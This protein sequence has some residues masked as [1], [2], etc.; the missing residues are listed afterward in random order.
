MKRIVVINNPA[1]GNQELHRDLDQIAARFKALADE[2][3]V[4][5]TNRPGD[6]ARAI[7]QLAPDADLIVAA[8]GD[9]TVHECV[10]ALCPMEKRP[11]F[12]ILPGGTCNDFSRTLGMSQ[13]HLEAAEQIL[14]MKIR[15]VDVGKHG[16]RYFLNFW[17]VGLITRVS[18]QINSETKKRWGRLAYY[19]SALQKLGLK[20]T[21]RLDVTSEGFR[22]SGD[23][24]M[25]LVGNGTHVGGMNMYFPQSNV[26]DGFLD[27][28]IVRELSFESLWSLLVSR[29]TDQLP[30]SGD[31]LCFRAQEL[32]VYTD[33]IQTVD[34]DGEKNATTPARLSVLPGHLRMVTGDSV[35]SGHFSG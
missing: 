8:G 32:S 4:I 33:P 24:T 17:G 15:P 25:M 26:E 10:N 12:A 7:R 19:L 27:V 16:D 34:M 18:E 22:Y 28:L 30:T 29:I 9:G 31:L 1:A 13:N 35:S 20:E 11:C 21:F 2:V 3:T 5:R 6:G 23:A 14:E